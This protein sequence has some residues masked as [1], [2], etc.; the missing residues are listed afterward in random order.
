MG[1]SL[2][3]ILIISFGD[4]CSWSTGTVLFEH[5]EDPKIKIVERDY[6]CGAT[7]SGSPVYK[8]FRRKE[9]TSYL[10]LFTEIDTSKINKAEWNKV[11]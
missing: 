3:F 9:I 1:V 10:S 5:K 8:V 4:M 7:D 2:F 11:K 6:G